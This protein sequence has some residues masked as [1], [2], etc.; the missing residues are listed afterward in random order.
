MR[1]LREPLVHFVLVAAVIVGAQRI[2][3]VRSDPFRVVMTPERVQQLAESYQLQFNVEPDPDLREAL[4]EQDFEDEVL[5]R[6]ALAMGLD[7]DDEIIR[8]RLIQKMRFVTEDRLAP[9]EPTAEELEAYFATHQAEYRIRP[10]ATFTHVFFSVDS[11]S[12]EQARARALAQLERLNQ[13]GPLRAPEAGD[14]FPDLYDFSLYQPQQV[15]RLFGQTEFSRAV[16]TVPVERWSGPFRSAYGWHLVRVDERREAVDPP[17]EQVSDRVRLDFLE[18]A[19]EAANG[20]ALARM[21]TQYTLVRE[22]QA[23]GR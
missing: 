20:E 12:D 5:Y 1:A 8:R 10:R 2:H 17:F 7:E 21:K 11:R 9:S 16:F 23:G 19:Q 15:Q 18:E 4:V 13:T 22:D 3:A 14:V 6:Q